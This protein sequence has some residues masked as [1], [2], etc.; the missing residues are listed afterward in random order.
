MLFSNRVR[1]RVRIIFSVWTV[2][3]YAHVLVLVVTVTLL[4]A[5][6]AMHC[7]LLPDIYQR[8]YDRSLAS[9]KAMFSVQ[10][11]TAASACN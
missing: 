9:R 3:C 5:E 4:T 2:S 8:L 1:V 6:G 7:L 11:L 10:L